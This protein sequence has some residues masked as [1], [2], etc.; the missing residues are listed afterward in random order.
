MSKLKTWPRIINIGGFKARLIV[1][2]KLS[3]HDL[4]LLGANGTVS[5]YHKG[6]VHS[7]KVYDKYGCHTLK[8]VLV[9]K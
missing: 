5:V 7:G 6:K 4:M 3:P 2:N 8:E 1:N 9:R